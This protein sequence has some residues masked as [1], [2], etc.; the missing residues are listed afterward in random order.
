[1]RHRRYAKNKI[2]LAAAVGLSYRRLLDYFR[3]SNQPEDHSP[4]KA[5]YDI[6]A[7]RRFIASRAVAYNR[8]SKNGQYPISDREQL[9]VERTCIAIEREKFRLGVAMREYLARGEVNRV[10]G[11]ANAV[12]RREID[13]A[14]SVELPP[15]LEGLSAMEIKK[16]L[17][18]K[19]DEIF[20]SLPK[21]LV[22]AY[23]DTDQELVATNFIT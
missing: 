4:G 21:R 5:R 11:T 1:V 14:I 12:V 15:R 23:G 8:G 16:V 3:D 10:I 17:R 6:E 22:N 18:Q 7:W 9:I 13:R 2:E 20:V 19:F